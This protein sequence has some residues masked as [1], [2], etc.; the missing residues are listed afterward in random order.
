MY[1]GLPD[2]GTKTCS[3]DQKPSPLRC[4][5]AYPY[6]GNMY[7]RAPSFR[8]LSNVTLWQSLESSLW[9][10]LSLTPDSVALNNPFFNIDDYLQ[11]N[12]QFF[13]SKNTHF[14]RTEVQKMGF[15]LSNQS[16]KPPPEF[17]PYYFIAYPYSFSGESL[18]L[19]YTSLLKFRYGS[20]RVTF[21]GVRL[22][23]HEILFAQ[24]F[25]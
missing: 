23:S 12:V 17:G 4:E 24:I 6:E 13:P 8:L 18:C 3:S 11:V 16:Y 15:S 2:C 14:K 9:T 21:V 22:G 1:T 5:C 10:K 25:L 20:K 19:L 7:F